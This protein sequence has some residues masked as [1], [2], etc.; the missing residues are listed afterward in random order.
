MLVMYSRW[1][2]SAP[3]EIA[4]TVRAIVKISA[5]SS[6][7]LF[8]VI[9]LLK[10]VPNIQ[11]TCPRVL[12]RFHGRASGAITAGT[13][14]VSQGYIFAANLENPY[15]LTIFD[16]IMETPVDNAKLEQMFNAYKKIKLET[17]LISNEK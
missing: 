5:K 9:S 13:L 12:P 6:P 4:L 7:T 14:H 17:D 1:P 8:N 2:E 15:F 3:E 10:L 11:E 16:S